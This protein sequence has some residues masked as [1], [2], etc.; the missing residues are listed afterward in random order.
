M[1][2]TPAP[3]SRAERGFAFGKE[4]TISA[5]GFPKQS[6]KLVFIALKKMLSLRTS[7]HAGV[8]TEGNACGAIR[9]SFHSSITYPV[10]RRVRIA[11]SLRSSQ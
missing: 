8:V 2:N 9:S 11:T 6:D 10:P 7:A 3:R 1:K 5:I 4:L